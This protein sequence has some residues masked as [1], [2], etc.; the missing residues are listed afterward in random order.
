MTSKL[1]ILNYVFLFFFLKFDVNTNDE[2]DIPA[3]SSMIESAGYVGLYI[4]LRQS[5]S[6]LILV[7][8]G[9]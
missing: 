5:V 2:R 4:S 6:K 3:D 1:R 9:N 8:I 7:W